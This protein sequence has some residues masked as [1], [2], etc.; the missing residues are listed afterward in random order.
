MLGLCYTADFKNFT[1]VAEISDRANI[2]YPSMYIYQDRLY[3]CFSS[4]FT[5]G[6]I[7][8]SILWSSYNLGKL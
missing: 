8:A 7:T 3:M 6:F 2:T 5:G 4:G 1:E